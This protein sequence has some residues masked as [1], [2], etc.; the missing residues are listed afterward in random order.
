M[1]FR[2]RESIDAELQRLQQ[3]IPELIDECDPGDVL[4][5]FAAEAARLTHHVTAEHDAYVDDRIS[6]MLASAGLIPGE[7][8]GEACLTGAVRTQP[9]TRDEIDARIRQIEGEIPALTRDMDRFYREFEDRTDRLCAD[10]APE[11]EAYI[12]DRLQQ[13]V[14]RAGINR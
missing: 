4:E 11:D 10:A 1:D 2:T 3:R 12:L 5:A 13:M 8:E 14:G 7:S 9:L 6:C